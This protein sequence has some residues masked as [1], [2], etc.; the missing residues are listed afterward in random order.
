MA[1]ET[2]GEQTGTFVFTVDFESPEKYAA[3]VAAMDEDN[4]LRDLTV[5][6][7]RS[8]SPIT[9]LSTA[10]SSEIPLPNAHKSGR[11][12]II[13]V[14]ITKVAL[15]RFDGAIHEADAVATLLEKAGAVGVQVFSL[16]YAGAQSGCL[17]LAVEW[18]SAK[19]QAQSAA[20]WASDPFGAQMTVSM[21]NGTS[22]TTLLSSALYRDIPL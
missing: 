4:E 3:Q 18:P 8:T 7:T 6:L 14:H 12:S 10:V 13:E 19:A 16:S 20:V 5:S 2:A 22:A 9:M 11:G 15:G 21:L 17:G 1:A